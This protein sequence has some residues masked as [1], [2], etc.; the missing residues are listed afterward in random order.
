M[1]TDRS[2]SVATHRE[3][4]FL[5]GFLQGGWS[6]GAEKKVIEPDGAHIMEGIIYRATML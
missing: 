5:V 1:S 6:F 2:S 4:D 3:Q